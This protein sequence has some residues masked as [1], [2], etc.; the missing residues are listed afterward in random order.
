MACRYREGATV[1]QLADEFNI[2][3]RTASDRLKKAGVKMRL[4][5]PPDEMIDEM[6]RL[7]ESGSSFATIGKQLYASPQTVSHYVQR[8]GVQIR[9]AH[10]SRD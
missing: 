5:P 4:Q 3:R 9:N 10:K 1:Y 7:Y 2:D 8:R 6:V